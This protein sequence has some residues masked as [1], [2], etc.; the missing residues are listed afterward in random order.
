MKRAVF[1]TAA[2]ALLCAVFLS[3][4]AGCSADTAVAY[5]IVHTSQT[6]EPHVRSMTGAQIDEEITLDGAFDE[7]FYDDLNWYVGNKSVGVGAS[8]RTAT[9][10]MTTHIARNGLLIAFDVD[11]GWLVSYDP[12]RFTS[13][14]SCVELYLSMGGETEPDMNLYELDIVAGGES[15]YRVWKQSLGNS[16]NF[17]PCAYTYETAPAYA[18]TLKGGTISSGECT[19]YA[20][21]FWLPWEFF[22][23]TSRPDYVNCNPCLITPIFETGYDRDWYV[24]GFEQSPAVCHWARTDG[25]QFDRYG[26][27]S[28]ELTVTATG[29]TVAEQFGRDWC[30]TGD[31]L[32][33]F[34]TPED[35]KTL[36]SLYVNGEDY[37]ASAA[38]GQFTLTCEGDIEIA[39]TFE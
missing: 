14:N 22:G 2:A 17:D 39:A 27:V 20:I 26:F 19:G 6:Y 23:R 8:E 30:V 25:Y 29:G 32:T 11:E 3:V 31:E 33:F 13:N 18:I 15:R 35:G 10:R 38:G 5:N 36:T 34:V 1:L 21:E 4:F 12:T 28:N 24:F 7:A 16:N 9:L 37:T